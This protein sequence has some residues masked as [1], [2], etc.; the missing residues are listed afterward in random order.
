MFEF[1]NLLPV[2]GEFVTSL[3][4][5]FALAILPA[6]L[7]AWGLAL[8]NQTQILDDFIVWDVQGEEQHSRIEFLEETICRLLQENENLKGENLFLVEEVRALVRENDHLRKE[9]TFLKNLN[10]RLR[11][12]IMQLWYPE[13]IRVQVKEVV[14]KKPIEAM[15][16]DEMRAELGCGRKWNTNQLRALV[17]KARAQL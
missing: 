6:I 2:A 9:E 1:I 17:R 3:V 13:E 16:I 15:S 11:L 14:R 7:I 5:W 8:G 4:G 12:E 10:E